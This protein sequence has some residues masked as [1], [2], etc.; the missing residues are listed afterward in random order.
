MF[1]IIADV[2]FY[3]VGKGESAGDTIRRAVEIMEKSGV[4]CYPNSMATVLEAATLDEIF[5]AIKGAESEILRSGFKRVE[6]IIKIDH[7]TDKENTVKHKL[8]R[9]GVSH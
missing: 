1:M 9:I 6:T 5:N 4:H 3:P 8:D 2:T 7:R